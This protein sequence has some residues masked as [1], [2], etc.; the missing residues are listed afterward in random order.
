[1]STVCLIYELSIAAFHLVTPT[2]G[3]FLLSGD[4]LSFDLSTSLTGVGEDITGC[5]WIGF[6]LGVDAAGSM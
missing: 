5:D 6:G 4:L 1:M 3:A 2:G